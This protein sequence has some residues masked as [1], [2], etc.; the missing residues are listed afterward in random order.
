MR[1]YAVL[2][3]AAPLPELAGRVFRPEDEPFC[4]QPCAPIDQYVWPGEYRPPARA[5]MAWDESALHVLLCANEPTIQCE[6]KAFNGKVW[7]DSC[8]E[9]FI[10]PFEDDP[11]YMNIEINA[12]GTALIAIGADRN[13]RRFLDRLP[14]GMDIQTSRHEGG[15][16]AIAYRIPFALLE[17]LYG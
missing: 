8:L 13:D 4:R 3:L 17:R 1:E 16:W 7:R 11:R 2:P 5:W 15:W 10:R 6:A 12:E 14:E 9:C